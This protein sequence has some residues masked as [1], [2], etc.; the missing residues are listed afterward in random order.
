MSGSMSSIGVIVHRG[1]DA[2]FNAF[3]NSLAEHGYVHG[4]T[5]ALEPRFA[6]GLLERTTGFAADL[7]ARKVDLI[8]AIGA[9]GARAAQRA[10]DQI[11]I[12][13]AIV[14]D[15]VEAGFAAA[16]DRPSGNMAGVTNY[17]PDLAVEQLILLKKTV[18]NL[19]RLAILSDVDIP[20]PGGWNP[21]ERSNEIAARSLGLEPHWIRIK[22]PK[23]DR[24]AAFQAMVGGGAQALQVLEV[25]VNLADFQSIAALAIEHRLPAMFPGGWQHDGLMAYGTS[26]LETVPELPKLISVI[27]NGAKPGD[28]PV[29]HVRQHRLRLNLATARNI[30]L[31]VSSEVVALASEVIS[32]DG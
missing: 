23:P 13:Y 30:G 8:V 4:E 24:A 31:D 20:R 10:T 3:V 15:P 14:L 29:R 25:P 9:V 27:L 28:I 12:V 16:L 7:V 2:M 18:P 5:I 26:L 19:K 32:I 1:R 22:G 17:D 21:L 6:E 11:P